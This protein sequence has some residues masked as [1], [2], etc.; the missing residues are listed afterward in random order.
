MKLSLEYGGTCFVP[1]FCTRTE[2][3]VA[4]P[5]HLVLSKDSQHAR[6]MIEEGAAKG[7]YWSWFEGI[8]EKV[9]GLGDRCREEG[10]RL[11]WVCVTELFPSFAPPLGWITPI[12][13]AWP[14]FV[15][16]L[17]LGIGL[18][19]VIGQCDLKECSRRRKTRP[20]AASQAVPSTNSQQSQASPPTSDAAVQCRQ[21]EAPL[22]PPSVLESP[23]VYRAAG[24]TQGLFAQG[25][26]RR[27]RRVVADL[28][29]LNE[30]IDA[31]EGRGGSSVDTTTASSI[32]SGRRRGRTRTPDPSSSGIDAGG[33]GGRHRHGL[34]P[35]LPG[36][37]AEATESGERWRSRLN[38]SRNDSGFWWC[39]E[40]S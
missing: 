30:F 38:V 23:Q 24:V 3:A 1:E 13:F 9:G 15:L 10:H 14:W 2:R 6:V 31:L 18:G 20:S 33:G 40:T 36:A 27:G 37:A 22:A 21:V 5:L 26:P 19:I 7:H 29:P 35:L 34:P 32:P 17:A 12:S 28:R 16:G 8:E 4:G 25:K 39:S 11:V